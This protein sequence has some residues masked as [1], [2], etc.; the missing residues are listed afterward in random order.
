MNDI[1]CIRQPFARGQGIVL[2]G[3]SGAGK[4]TLGGHLSYILGLP[5]ID[6]DT[7]IERDIDCINNIF[8]NHSEI[9]FRFLEKNIINKYLTYPSVIA[10]GAGAWEDINTRKAVYDSRF[11]IL[12]L[13]ESPYNAWTRIKNCSFRPLATTYDIFISRWIH[14]IPNWSTELAVNPIGQT[15]NLLAETLVNHLNK[16]FI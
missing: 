15:P 13:A 8:I 14:R 2:I 9:G 12:W 1:S 11:A 10:L 3:G 4:T 16:V 6:I 7:I 5:F